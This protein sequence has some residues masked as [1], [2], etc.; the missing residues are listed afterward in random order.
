MDARVATLEL[1]WYMRNQLLRNPDWAGMTH[2]LEFRVSLV[3][4]K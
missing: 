4:V 1:S 2:S 3:D